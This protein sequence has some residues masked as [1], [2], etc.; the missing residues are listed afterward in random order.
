MKTQW[1][2]AVVCCALVLVLPDAAYAIVLEELYGAD[3]Y[4]TA[5]EVSKAM[6]PAAD[7]AGSVVVCTGTNY[8]DAI[9]AGPLAYQ[10]QG[11][12][13][14]SGANALSAA[15][16]A[17]IERILPQGGSVYI[18]GGPSAVPAS[19]EAALRSRGY[20]VERVGGA[21]RYETSAL[22]ARELVAPDGF[23]IA[24]GGSFTDALCASAPAAMLGIPVLLTYG[25][26]LPDSVSSYLS[27]EGP[28]DIAYIA[29]GEQAVG[30][31]VVQEIGYYASQTLVMGGK[32]RYETGMLLTE[33]FWNGP[34]ISPGIATGAAY[35]DGLTGAVLC[36][37]RRGPLL[38]TPP[39]A[40]SGSVGAYLEGW[41]PE[42]V[43]VFG[44]PEALSDNVRSALKAIR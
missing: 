8:P 22:V 14:L 44:G 12:I 30:S 16:L 42:T 29:G 28:F 15:T 4:G 43:M 5:I 20:S 23:F 31:S 6:Y 3:R 2:A 10:E 41:M 21:D 40:L 18:V 9:V 35:P 34:V 33:G 32:D 19:A 26:Y 27:T 25:W 17:E 1:F 13:L 24:T 36:A 37:R 39:D 38:I 7:S 11:P